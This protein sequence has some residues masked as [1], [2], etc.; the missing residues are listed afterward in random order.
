MRF[1]LLTAVT[2]LCL[3]AGGLLTD[4]GIATVA[5]QEVSTPPVAPEPPETGPRPPAPPATPGAAPR[6][7]EVGP[8]I[9]YLQDDAGRLVPVPGFRYSDFVELFRMQEGLPGAVRPPA[10]VLESL[11]L[12][13]DLDAVEAAACPVTVDCMV[14]QTRGGW[15]HVPLDL[16]GL[17]I[18]APARHEGPGR[19]L[20]D[21]PPDGT[22]YRVWFEATPDAQGDVTQRLT[23]EGRIAVEVDEQS[24]AFGLRLPTANTTRVD[25][26]SARPAPDVVVQPPP[27]RRPAVTPD[28]DGSV[29]SIAGL[30][31]PVRVRV[32]EAGRGAPVWNAVPQAA[33]ESVVRIDG[34]NAF[35]DAVVTL[36]N[37]RPDIEQV[38]IALPARTT[39]RQVRGG[40][41]L[42]SRGGTE[43]KPHVDI[44]VD[45]D[46][47]GS[48]T[49]ELECE[50]P[51]DP[52]AGSAFEAIGFTV[53]QVASWRQWGRVSLVV[54]GDWR[55]EWG[56]V[57][58]LRRVDPPPAA[59]RPGFVAAFAY[60]AQPA[61][62][63]VRVRPR[64]SRVVIE[65][66]YRYEVGATR[67][68]LLARLRVAARGAPATSVALSIDPT[69]GIDD[70]GPPGMVDTTAV[71]V[72]GGRITIPFLQALSGDAVIEVRAS[73]A[74]E[75]DAD[76]LAWRLPI[77][78]ADLVGP[79]TVIITADS[80]IEIL[81]D[82][83][84]ESGLTR[85]AAG[86]PP[87]GD[88]ERA[89]LVYRADAGEAQFSGTRRFLPRRV[90]AAINT[91]VDVESAEMSVVETIRL[92]VVHVPLEYV[93]LAV[94][95]AVAAAGTLEL[96]QDDLRLDPIDVSEPV[97]AP[98]S[99]GVVRTV[100]AI[101]AMPLL[102]SGELTVRYRLPTPPVEPQTTVA[103]DLPLVLPIGARI[104]RQTVS[105]DA[106]ETLAVDV[107]GDAWRRDSGLDE[108]L[109]SWVAG[110]RQDRV[111]LAIVSRP[112]VSTGGTVVEAAWLQTRLLADRREDLHAC[113][114]VGAGD[115]VVIEVP[116]PDDPQAEC[117]VTLDG[118]PQSATT[119]RDEALVFDLP[120]LEAGR[121]RLVEIRTSVPRGRGWSALAATIG[122]P[123]RVR[124]VAPTFG[125]TVTQRR[126]YWEIAVRPD[127]YLL[128]APRRWTAQQ[129]WRLGG[130]GLEPV[131]VVPPG[132]LADWIVRSLAAGATD[133]V[134]T[135]GG[136]EPPS[137]AT[138][139]VY[140]GVGAPGTA[141]LLLVPVWCAVLVASGFAL[142]L[143][144]ALA[145]VPALRRPL[146]VVPVGAALALAAAAF[147]DAAPLAVQAA[148]P[149]TALALVA[150]LL[151]GW[152]DR[153]RSTA[154]APWAASPSDL[155]RDA[156]PSPSLIVA[157]SAAPETSSLTAAA[158]GAS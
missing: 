36:E 53:A 15:V 7:S 149:G 69:W 63:A 39:L 9:F 58:G 17:L 142:A 11:T 52:S 120:R 32:A 48:V 68:G 146:A 75:R 124:L 25:I 33:V 67:I 13:V 54:E 119:R 127:E 151:R 31:G 150:W 18:T 100:R 156:T 41:T 148:L 147:P 47:A 4:R 10:A 102:G 12:R 65:P 157:P 106:S 87:R 6:V 112:R 137:A 73:R 62:L 40:G 45:R 38:R 91:R 110:R 126:F 85:Q 89:A 35:I 139:A 122:M 97:D 42:L 5:A 134:V 145:Y 57:P 131:P 74:I 64:G 37:L 107:R 22:G 123:D 140:S 51:I 2:G 61:S 86:G 46:A 16:E 144:L 133:R 135:L 99:D 155:V 20:L 81:P 108:A 26:R 60:D 27:Q 44:A 143:G 103:A 101:L 115:R 71:V 59:R 125:G 34:R 92:D 109:R 129:R 82:P 104:D 105:L 79:A 113:V 95:E 154:V 98:A 130:G 72:D 128:A 28:G 14:R 66:E 29:V 21:T 136:G 76:R 141:T 152:L 117:D 138:R 132:A 78:K 70:V 80:D 88:A 121:R 1:R 83:L 30:T 55:A 56:D 93:E 77:P 96:R 19:M 84:T 8:E 114:L 90:D 158:R 43:A 118:V 50:R 49:F 94:P 3:V 153:D 24:A 111:P 116:C 23:L